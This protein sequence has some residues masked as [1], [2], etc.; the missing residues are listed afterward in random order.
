M[1]RK[2][3]LTVASQF[4]GI[5]VIRCDQWKLGWHMAKAVADGGMRLIE[6]T[7]NSDCPAELIHQLRT[8]LPDCWIGAG[9]LLTLE[10]MRAAI[11]A[12]AQFLF[13][14]HVEPGLIRLAVE[15]EIAVVPGALSPT[16]IVQAWQA[17]ASSVKVFPVHSLGGVEYIRSLQ[18]P[19]G[20]IP[21]IPTGG[22]TVKNAPEFLK[23][24]AIAVGLSGSLFPQTVLHEQNWHEITRRAQILVESWQEIE[25]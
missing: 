20:Q 5:A 13:T 11:A 4:R 24:G 25:A 3:W 16:E 14:P 22:V 1:E 6:V 9:T 17:G 8:D 23:A 7:W 19:L 2:V 18:G 21:L 15:R 10:Q 12:G